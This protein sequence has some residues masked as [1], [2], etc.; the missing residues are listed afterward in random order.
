MWWFIG[1]IIVIFIINK[2]DDIIDI[3][4]KKNSGKQHEKHNKE[5]IQNHEKK[6]L[7]KESIHQMVEIEIKDIVLMD[8]IGKRRIKVEVLDVDDVW[9]E[10]KIYHKRKKERRMILALAAIEYHGTF[11]RKEA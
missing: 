2:L 7:L 5:K 10:V 9:V 11:V 3:L 4:K 6:K 1:F 8:R